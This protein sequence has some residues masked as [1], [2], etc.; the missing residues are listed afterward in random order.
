MQTFVTLLG[1]I[2]MYVLCTFVLLSLQNLFRWARV[3]EVSDLKAIE[4]PV[5]RQSHVAK[6]GRKKRNKSL[7]PGRSGFQV[8][9]RGKRQDFKKCL[10][11]SRR[12]N[13][14]R[15]VF[16]ENVQERRKRGQ[17]SDQ[18]LSKIPYSF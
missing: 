10:E 16:L 9:S 8:S 3:P 5:D 13:N 18:G 2:G 6:L 4:S 15:L 17:V 11:G 14:R 7:F 1:S 12:A